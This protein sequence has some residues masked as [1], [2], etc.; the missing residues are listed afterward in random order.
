MF[1]YLQE[2]YGCP[3]LA[4][5]VVRTKVPKP[6]NITITDAERAKLLEAAPPNLRC[7]ILMCSDLAIRSG[8][9]TRLSPHHYDS[10]QGTLSFRTKYDNTQT[11]PVTSEL[12]ALLDMAAIPDAPFVAQLPRGTHRVTGWRIPNRPTLTAENLRERFQRL[13]KDCG[14]TRRIR[15]HDLR[16]TTARKVWGMTKDLRLVQGLLGHD[17]LSST[18]WY[19]QAERMVVPL[20]TLELA[21]LP[22]QTEGVQ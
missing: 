10:E 2:D 7:L 5:R 21:R 16:R 12:K 17:D 22:T 13:C 8:T 9:A 11:V 20:S 4:R 1:T 19:L 15:L 14:I 6:R 3:P 18:L